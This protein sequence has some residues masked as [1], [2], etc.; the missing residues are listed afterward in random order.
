MPR[1]RAG[2]GTRRDR[3][4]LGERARA[5]IVGRVRAEYLIFNLVIV[6]MPLLLALW[7]PTD[8]RRLYLPAFLSCLVVAVPYLVWDSLAAGAHWEFNPAH[9]LGPRLF[10]LPIEEVLFFF[11][12][13]F[14]CLYTWIILLRGEDAPVRPGLRFSYLLLF[15]ALPVGV[16]ALSLGKTYTGWMLIAL[17]S[18]AALDLLLRTS[19]AMRPKFWALVVLVIGFTLIFNGY[20]TAR[21]V[22][23][24]REAYQI[25]LRVFTIPIEDFGYGIGL[26]YACLAVFVRMTARESPF[27]NPRIER[28]FNGYRH[29]ANVIDETRPIRSERA[30]RTAVIGGGLAGLTAATYLADRGFSVTLFEAKHHLGGKCGS[31]PTALENGERVQTEHGFHAFFRQYHNLRRLLAHVGVASR[32]R[33]LDDYLIV[34]EDGARYSFRHVATTPGMNLVSLA[35]NGVYRLGPVVLGGAGSRME[36]FLRYERD[37]TFAEYDETSF[38]T[39]AKAAMLPRSLELLFTTFARAFFADRER[40]SMAELIK[41]FHFY[42]LSNDCG[43]LYDHLTVDHEPGLIAPLRERLEQ[44][45]ARIELATP[46]RCLEKTGAGFEIQGRVFDDVVLATSVP[47]TRAIV[48]APARSRSPSWPAASRP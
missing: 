26:V 1:L 9:V 13:P 16:W 19:L 32:L 28:A 37:T 18:A 30:S 20:L 40:M 47:G 10:G 36:S 34:G 15:A 12:V 33:A 44:H 2:N 24:Y 5:G 25:G 14:A 31:W 46:V 7:P 23:T 11:T 42:Y 8:F 21:P 29:L 39:W 41:G 6:A 22:V 27:L 17:G 45:G 3:P 43:L 48:S 38:D 35:W 4:L